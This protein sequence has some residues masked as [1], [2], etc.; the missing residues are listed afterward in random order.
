MSNS[1]KIGS[2]HWDNSK[3]YGFD[4]TP[5]MVYDGDYFAKYQVM[6]LSDMGVKLTQ[7]RV[8][9][10]NKYYIGDDIVDIGVG[11]GRFC[12]ELG[13]YGYDVSVEA[14]KWLKANGMY[15]DPYQSPSDAL[16]FW[17]SLEHIPDPEIIIGQAKRWVFVSMPIYEDIEHCFASKH[18]KPGEH[19]HYWTDQGLIDWFARRGFVCIDCHDAETQIGREGILSYAFKRI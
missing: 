2:L 7:A 16:T 13:A 10:V 1:L 17:D 19:L 15:R 14:I 18:Y 6:D 11:G 8:E 5:P 4:V 3:G 12:I 9:F